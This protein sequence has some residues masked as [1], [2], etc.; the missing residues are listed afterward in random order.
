LKDIRI[1][2]ESSRSARFKATAKKKG[3]IEKKERRGR[4]YISEGIPT[5]LTFRELEKLYDGNVFELNPRF[6]NGGVPARGVSERRG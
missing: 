2:E 1:K 5:K 3:R 4:N 6:D